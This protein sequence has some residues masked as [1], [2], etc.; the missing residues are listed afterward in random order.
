MYITIINVIII[1]VHYA[2]LFVADVTEPAERLVTSDMPRL[3]S[4]SIYKH[5]YVYTYIY[6]YIH[7]YIYIYILSEA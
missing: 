6:I 5:Y 3:H 4:L 2:L 1:I 7:K